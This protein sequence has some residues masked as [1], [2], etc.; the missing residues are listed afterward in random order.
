MDLSPSGFFESVKDTIY[1][2]VH[3]YD[4]KGGAF[5]GKI[6]QH[7]TVREGINILRESPLLSKSEKDKLDATH[8]A[9]LDYELNGWDG[10]TEGSLLKKTIPTMGLT[11]I[12]NEDMKRR[13]E[14]VPPDRIAS[15][16]HAQGLQAGITTTTIIAESDGTSRITR[17][18]RMGVPSGAPAGFNA[19]GAQ[20]MEDLFGGK[21]DGKQGNMEKKDRARTPDK[22]KKTKPDNGKNSDKTD[23]GADF[24]KN[25]RSAFF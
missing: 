13:G 23:F 16:A 21:G 11:D 17:S 7:T 4:F 19:A 8:R 10:L 25:V 5:K 1:M 3:E 15:L 14:Y 6:T 12:F 22:T 24:K 18:G 20:E 2:G 9:L